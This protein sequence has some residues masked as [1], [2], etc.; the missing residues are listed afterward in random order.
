MTGHAAADRTW[1]DAVIEEAMPYK[2]NGDRL[3]EIPRSR[4]RITN[5]PEY[6]Q[7]LVRRG[8]LTFWV[9]EEALAAWHACGRQAVAVKPFIL[10]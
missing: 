7:A 5:R 4:Y 9:T 1:L 8:S 3:H 2:A 10:M 6:D